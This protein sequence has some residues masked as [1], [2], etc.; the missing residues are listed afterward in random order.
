MSVCLHV[1]LCT[2]CMLG[3]HG[4]QKSVSDPLQLVL[5]IVGTHQ[6]GDGNQAHVLY[7]NKCS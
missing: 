2:T 3:T 4:D 6:V 1:W 5:Q 7:K